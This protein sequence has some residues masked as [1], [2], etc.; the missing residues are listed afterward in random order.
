MM[1]AEAVSVE[2]T[3]G[4]RVFEIRLLGLDEAEAVLV[5]LAN[6]GGFALQGIGA[7]MVAGG[8]KGRSWEALAGI[9]ATGVGGILAKLTAPQLKA[10]REAFAASCAVRLTSGGGFAALSDAQHT[11]FRGKLDVMLQWLV[12]CVEVNFSGFFDDVQAKITAA[13]ALA[14]RTAETASGSESPP[15]S[16]GDAIDS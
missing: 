7:D 13:I 2:R 11:V 16:T 10:L 4:G 14:L 3:I 9:A 8:A 6:L 5:Q 15:E 12:A 1:Q